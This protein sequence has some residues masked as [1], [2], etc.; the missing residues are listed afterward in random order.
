MPTLAELRAQ[1]SR[2]VP[3][4]TVTVTLVEGQ[5]LLDEV[6]SL[7]QE[8]Q[9]L[10]VQ[11]SRTNESGEKTGPPKRQGESRPARIDEIDEAIKAMDERLAEHQGVVTLH[12]V[13]GGE[14]QQWKDKHPARDGNEADQLIAGGWCNASDL[15]FDLGRYVAEWDGE[16]LAAGDWDGWLADRIVYADRRSLVSAVVGMHENQAPRIPKSSS[17]SSLT[18]PGESASPSP[19]A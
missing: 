2:P 18:Q 4:A 16:P 19:E 5:H 15:F 13:S 17:A 12:G 11:H 9:D 3:K 7:M 8:R 10:L 1:K 14:W 6:Q